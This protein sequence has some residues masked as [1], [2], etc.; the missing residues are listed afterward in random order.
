METFDLPVVEAVP[1]ETKHIETFLP[2]NQ[3]Y[4]NY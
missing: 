2:I 4:D 3:I 1:P